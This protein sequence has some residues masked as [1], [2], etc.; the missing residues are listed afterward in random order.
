MQDHDKYADEID[1]IKMM[2]AD[3]EWKQPIFMFWLL[4]D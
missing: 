4:S 2:L 1:K 3:N